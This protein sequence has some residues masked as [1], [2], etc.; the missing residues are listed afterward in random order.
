M[1]WQEL[2]VDVFLERIAD[3]PD[4]EAL[5]EIDLRMEDFE[6]QR[7]VLNTAF[8]NLAG[9]G[10]ELVKRERAE[11]Q[12]GLS[13]INT[14]LTKIRLRRHLIVNRM[15]DRKWGKAVR[16]VFGDEGFEQC[17]VWMETYEGAEVDHAKLTARAT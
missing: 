16:A 17:R 5:Q 1:S 7:G 4:I 11:L 14:D 3:M 2:E 12:G 13:V 10:G 8:A 9:R 15:N 6:L